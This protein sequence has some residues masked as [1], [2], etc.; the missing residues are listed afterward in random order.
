MAGDGVFFFL[1]AGIRALHRPAFIP[2]T[3]I[4]HRTEVYICLHSLDSLTLTSQPALLSPATHCPFPQPG[5]FYPLP[6]LPT[7]LIFPFSSTALCLHQSI[8]LL[9]HFPPLSPSLIPRLP[10]SCPSMASILHRPAPMC[11]PGLRPRPRALATDVEPDAV[12][13]TSPARHWS[14]RPWARPQP[15]TRAGLLARPRQHRQR[16]AAVPGSRRP[17]AAG[18]ARTNTSGCDANSIYSPARIQAP[19]GGAQRCE[20]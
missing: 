4:Y 11:G 17:P 15:G 2:H 16:A 3:C 9:P 6:P 20:T 8:N 7:S 14:R 13:G 18:P 19:R 1:D 12:L 5:F 10:H